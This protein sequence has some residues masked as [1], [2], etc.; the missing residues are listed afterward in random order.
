MSEFT[1]P[2][3][4]A[5]YYKNF[6]PIKPLMNDTQAYYESSRCLFCYD[7][8]CVNACPTHIDIPL[9]I[10]QIN[11]GNVT[12][13]AK[14]I[15]DSNYF[16]NA[17]GKVCPTDVLC[18]GSCVYNLQDV[19]P[20]E[21][22]RLQSYATTRVISE[23]QKLY[24]TGKANGK[25]IAV[26]GAGP[27]GISCACELRQL[28]YEVD[29]FE[30]KEKPSGLTLYGVAPYKITNDEALSEIKYLQDQFGFKIKF[31]TPVKTKEDFKELEKKYDAI[32][33]GIGLGETTSIHIKGEELE[34]SVGAVEFIS[35]IRIKKFKTKVGRKVIVL[36]G[37]NTAMDAA[38]ES[39]RMG[40]EK[41]ILAYRRS[42]DEMGAYDFEFELAKNAGVEGMFN[43]SPV[44]IIGNGKVEGV[45]FRKTDIKN[46]KSE[47]S[48]FTEYCD[49]VIRATGQSK[50][51]S[52]LKNIDGLRIDE[53]GK[54]I[55]N[56]KTYQ[57]DNHKYFAAG[58]VYNGGVEV[59]NAVAEAQDAAGGIHSYLSNLQEGIK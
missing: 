28:G 33:L 34:N 2:K 23:N 31:N 57:T 52:V 59:V 39:A 18:E 35:E 53:K 27:A 56:P 36:G 25:K 54:V 13:A 21:I 37:G 24:N 7:A 11:S 1:K 9:F 19:K 5:E 6:E 8:P 48:E 38:S 30:E 22:G 40:A 17:C 51:I 12:G 10:R 16:G 45:R 29:I 49:M 55:A 4:E 46:E 15:Y 50:Q 42:K 47:D 44:E 43:V 32:F 20:I 26:I 3:N 14:T 58:D 41:V